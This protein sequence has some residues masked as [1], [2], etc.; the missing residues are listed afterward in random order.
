M[1]HADTCDEL[2]RRIVD[3]AK[4]KPEVITIDSPW[5][6]FRLGLKCDDLNPSLAQASGALAKAQAMLSKERAS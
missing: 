4:E 2:C 1:T 3:L 6:L 5:D